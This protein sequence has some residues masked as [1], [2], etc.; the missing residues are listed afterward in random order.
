MMRWVAGCLDVFGI[1][2]ANSRNRS[3]TVAALFGMPRVYRWCRAA[4]VRE[5]LASPKRLSTKT[6]ALRNP[7]KTGNGLGSKLIAKDLERSVPRVVAAPYDHKT[8]RVVIQLS[9]K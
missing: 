3:L 2:A 7:A 5:R 6:Q 4:T 8:G 9:S 1:F